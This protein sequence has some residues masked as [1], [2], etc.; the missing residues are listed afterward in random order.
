[1]KDLRTDK[2]IAQVHHDLTMRARGGIIMYSLVWFMFVYWADIYQITPFAFWLNSL[3]FVAVA[4]LRLLHYLIHIKQPDRRVLIMYQWLMLLV[5]SGALHWGMMTAWLVQYS[6]YQQLQ[7]PAMIILA[8]FAVGGTATL[9]ISTPIRKLY[10]LFMFVPGITALLLNGGNSMESFNLSIMAIFAVIYILNASAASSSDYYAAINNH[11]LA[12]QRAEKLEILSVT[13]ALTQLKNR[14]Y[15]NERFDEEWSRCIRYQHN[16]C[17][18]MIDLDYFKSI[19]DQYG[20]VCGDECLKSV[21]RVLS[22]EF[23]RGTDVVAR[24]GG[25]EFVVLLPNTGLN[26]A[27]KLASRLLLH[28]S[29]IE[30]TCKEHVISMTCSIGIACALPEREI[31]NESLLSAADKALYCAKANGRNQWQVADQ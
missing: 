10:A 15:F 17:V 6:P 27:Q 3:L 13:D 31:N 11:E 28:I 4:L 7:Y 12:D 2:M 26:N 1:M 24:Y 14:M 23:R 20:H 5:L 9:S 16:L 8:A 19:N 25:E 29:Q 18:M 22:D 21:A 30:L